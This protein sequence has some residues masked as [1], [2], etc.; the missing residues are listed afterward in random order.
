MSPRTLEEEMSV[1]DIIERI[2]RAGV[3]EV[4]T[5]DLNALCDAVEEDRGALKDCAVS[6]DN[7]DTCGV[8]GEHFDD[9]EADRRTVGDVEEPDCAGARARLVLRL[10][11]A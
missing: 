6:E 9:C 2:R 8:C 5:A 11:G 3:D 10:I 1:A 4:N 7:P